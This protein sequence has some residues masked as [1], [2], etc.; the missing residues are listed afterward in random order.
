MI[1]LRPYQEAALRSLWGYFEETSGSPIVVLP[2]A[3]GKSIVIAEWIRGTLAEFPDTGFLVLSH[4][5]ELLMQN[6]A[7]LIGLWPEAPAGIYSASLGRRDIGSQVMFA[8][9]ASIHKRAFKIPRRIDMVLIDECHLVGNNTSSM[10]RAFLND[11]LVCNPNMKVIGLSASPYRLGSGLL[12]DGDDAL[13]TDIAYEAP[14]LPLIAAG[15]LSPLVTTPTATT[16]DVSS[17]GMSGGDYVSG[18]LERAVDIDE[19]TASAVQ[20]IVTLGADRRSWLVFCAGVKHSGHVA[21]AIRNHGVTCGTITGQTDKTERAY[22]LAEFKAGRLR[23]LT[24]ANCL[25]TGINVRGIDLLAFLRP[26]KSASLYVQ[27][28]G[29]GMRLSPE[30]GKTDALVLD[31]ARL[32]DNFGPVDNVKIKSKKGDGVAPT[33]MCKECEER[34]FASARMCPNCGTEFPPPEV[35]VSKLTRTASTG[36]ILSSQTVEPEWIDV[37][38]VNYARHEKPGKPPSVRVDYQCG[39][40]RHSSWWCPEH[41]G[42]ARQ[43]FVQTWQQHAPGQQVPNTVED[44]LALAGQLRKPVSISVRPAGKFVEILSARFA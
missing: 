5:A 33:K 32:I 14:I 44:T 22:L 10:Y 3:S 34:V 21:E 43:K 4:V 35:V 16:L 36:A 1:E 37:H 17:V 25:T 28:A 12:T 15:W 6:L 19:V 23:C 38:G 2:T 24:N 41:T 39:L 26:T 27:M 11:L 9:I 42:Y 40:S 18:Q 13:F 7:E 29:R 31:F 20:E 8:G 30:T